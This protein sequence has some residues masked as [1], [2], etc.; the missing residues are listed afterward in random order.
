[1]S[2]Q[3]CDLCCFS[4]NGDFYCRLFSMCGE[5]SHSL[6]RFTDQGKSLP[7][8]WNP[9]GFPSL[10]IALKQR[11]EHS[12][13]QLFGWTCERGSGAHFVGRKYL[14]SDWLPPSPFTGLNP[15]IQTPPVTLRQRIKRQNTS[16]HLDYDLEAGW[17]QGVGGW[18]VPIRW[19]LDFCRWDSLYFQPVRKLPSH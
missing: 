5:G 7:S 11:N 13:S 12:W 10:K 19:R 8:S 3:C 16:K 15:W 2:K 18:G 17:R 6:S 14:L 4:P 1:M 9:T